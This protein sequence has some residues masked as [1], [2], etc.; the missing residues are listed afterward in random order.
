MKDETKVPALTV[1][2]R[3]SAKRHLAECLNLDTRHSFNF[4][5]PVALLVLCG[6]LTWSK[7]F[8]R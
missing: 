5:V 3:L 6:V 4:M 1:A 8:E 7:V 2:P